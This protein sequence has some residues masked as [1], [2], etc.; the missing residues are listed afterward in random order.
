MARAQPIFRDKQQCSVRGDWLWESGRLI[1]ACGDLQGTP[2]APWRCS[3]TSRLRRGGNGLRAFVKLRFFYQPSA[4]TPPVPSASSYPL[5][6]SSVY[7]VHALWA[8]ATALQQKLQSV[9]LSAAIG[10][11]ITLHTNFVLMF[12][13]NTTRANS[14][15]HYANIMHV[16]GA[17]PGTVRHL[18]PPNSR[19]VW[20]FNHGRQIHQLP[21]CEGS[22]WY[23]Y[24][25]NVQQLS[26]PRVS[27]S[28]CGHRYPVYYARHRST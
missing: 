16:S 8:K 6:S 19:S 24:Y 15:R 13:T 2:I 27:L 23:Y 28:F 14:F 21:N 9:N 18:Y 12:P 10:R 26:A 20:S 3:S 17:Q 7:T 4:T 25:I 11:L 5:A 1:V 22:Q